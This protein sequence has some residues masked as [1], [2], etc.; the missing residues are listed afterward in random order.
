MP[1]QGIGE[2]YARRF[3]AGGR[4][5]AVADINRDK[6]ETVA[7]DLRKGGADAIFV[8]GRR[9]ER[10]VHARRWRRQCVDTWGRIDTLIA[11]AAIYYDID[12][13]NHSFEY[14]RKIFDVNYFG[15]WL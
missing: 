2:A 7:A 14:L 8:A 3:V 15:A 4:R 13:Q 5:V 1:A 11:N 9:L 10:G 6:G 12:N